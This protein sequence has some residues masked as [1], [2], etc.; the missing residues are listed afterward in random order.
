[1]NATQTSRKVEAALFIDRLSQQYQIQ[2]T[3]AEAREF[4]AQA[5]DYNKFE[6]ADLVRLVEKINEMIP[7]MDFGSTNPNTGRPHHRFIIGNECSRVIYV[8]VYKGYLSWKP[9]RYLLLAEQLHAA[10]QSAHADEAG[11]TQDDMNTFRFRFWWD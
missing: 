8:E 1:M 10:S 9:T 2:F 5:D 3:P 7:P 11:L 4:V 6:K